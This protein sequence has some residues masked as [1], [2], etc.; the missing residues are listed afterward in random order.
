MGDASGKRNS[1][2]IQQMIMVGSAHPLRRSMTDISKTEISFYVYMCFL[3]KLMATA[4]CSLNV[5]LQA[6]AKLTTHFV[7]VHSRQCVD[8]AEIAEH[9]V[10]LTSSLAS[11]QF[12]YCI[13]FNNYSYVCCK[14]GLERIYISHFAQLT[15]LSLVQYYVNKTDDSKLTLAVTV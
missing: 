1:T 8:E 13:I 5:V 3:G 14:H 15:R 4:V 2:R 7:R 9:V 6:L 11:C 10:G 12:R